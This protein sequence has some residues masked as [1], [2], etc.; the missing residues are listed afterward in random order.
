MTHKITRR[1]ALLGVSSTLL[2]PSACSS[3]LFGNR[4]GGETF[5]HGVASGDPDATSVVIWT[6]ISGVREAV[7]VDWYVARDAAM[8]NIVAHG[9]VQTS[10]ERDYTVKKW[11]TG[12]EPGTDYYYQFVVGDRHSPVGRSKTLPDTHLERLGFAVAS[13]SN[14]AFGFFN[15][16]E[17]IANDDAVDFVVHL[18]DYIYEHRA[19]GGYGGA[20]GRRIGRNHQPGHEIV[21]LEDYRIRHAQY[22]AD[23]QSRAMHARHPLIAVWDDHE[24][25]NNPWMRGAEN[26]QPT[27][28]DWFA[29]R[30]ASLQAWYEWMPVR[31]PAAS[32]APERYWRHYR[33]GDL[34]SLVTLETRHTGRTEQITWAGR[35]EDFAS[36]DDARSFYDTVIGAPQRSI[37][38]A[39]MQQFVRSELAESVAARRPWRLVGNQTVMGRRTSPRLDEPFFD[40]LRGQLGTLDRRTLDG[41]RRLGELDLPGDLDSWDGYPAARERFYALAREAGATDL[42]VLSGDSHGYFAN[43][44][45]DAAGMPMGVELATT[46]I[47]SPRFLLN[48]G[49]DATVR[50]DELATRHNREVVWA[51]SRYR[52]Y[53]RLTLTPQDAHADFITVSDVESRNYQTNVIKSMEVAPNNGS[54]R[55]A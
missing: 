43:E 2:L 11:L 9:Q 22:K 29:R 34:A 36:A 17:V 50:W 54:L 18:G 26:H 5:A 38:S 41:L 6:R 12:L 8:V 47:S 15:A 52:G 30:A 16:Y 21:S 1:D 55:F 32:A 44:L 42:I 33:F 10:A 24:S 49:M 40:N 7:A 13:C 19:R 51:E 4:T 14:Y 25:A 27:D 28:G 35:L 39:D 53:I 37:L 20:T 3:T 23:P 46:G 31:D 48:L 45:Y